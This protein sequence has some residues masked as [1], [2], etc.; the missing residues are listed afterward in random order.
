MPTA[1][2]AV[3]VKRRLTSLVSCVTLDGG[4]VCVLCDI[5]FLLSYVSIKHHRVMIYLYITQHVFYMDKLME[6]V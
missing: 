2:A 1:A 3:P 6:T 4:F 5:L